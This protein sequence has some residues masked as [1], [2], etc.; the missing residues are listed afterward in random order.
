MTK[1][2]NLVLIVI[3]TFV[4]EKHTWPI[5]QFSIVC[6]ENP[7]SHESPFPGPIHTCDPENYN[8][9]NSRWNSLSFSHSLTEKRNKDREIKIQ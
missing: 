9:N 5:Q 4:M 3:I 8:L 7:F 6:I 1:T 2:N